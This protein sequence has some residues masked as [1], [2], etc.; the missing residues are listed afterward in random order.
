MSG[1]HQ[2]FEQL[3]RA[4]S[5]DLYRYAFWLCKNPTIAEDLVQESFMRAWRSIDRLKDEKSAKAWLVTIVRRENARRFERFSPVMLELEAAWDQESEE[6]GPLETLEQQQLY[7]AIM[8]LEEKYREPLLLQ[9]IMG[10]SNIEIADQ[11]GEAQA[12]INTRLFRA[13]KLLKQAISETAESRVS[14]GENG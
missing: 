11:L 12:T 1:K 9:L 5:T 10:F 14:G 3:V 4:Y 7:Q 13:R 6:M 2:F 8:Q